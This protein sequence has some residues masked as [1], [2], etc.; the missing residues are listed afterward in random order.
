MQYSSLNIIHTDKEDCW[1]LLVDWMYPLYP[2]SLLRYWLVRICVWQK[3]RITMVEIIQ[4]ACQQVDF[5]TNKLIFA[6]FSFIILSNTRSVHSRINVLENGWLA[7]VV[8]LWP[9]GVDVT[10]HTNHIT[11]FDESHT[12]KVCNLKLSSDAWNALN[13]DY[14]SQCYG[15]NCIYCICNLEVACNNNYH[16]EEQRGRQYS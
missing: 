2:I 12:K 13:C 15:S 14:V 6:S 16:V 11:I 5:K 4:Y 9:S 10:N 1:V 3:T 8:L 7:F